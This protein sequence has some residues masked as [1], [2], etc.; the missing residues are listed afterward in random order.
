MPSRSIRWPPVSLTIGTSHF[1]ATSAILRSCAGVVTPP[2]ICGTTEKVPS[3]W[4][5]ACT[6]SLMNLA[7]FSSMYSSAHIILS[8]EASP[9]LDFASSAP[10]G[11]SAAKTED[12]DRRPCSMIAAI[13]S[14]LSIGI[15]GTYQ[16]ADG[17]STTA[18][19]AAHS[20]IW[21]T[22]VL[23]EPQPLPALVLSIT[24]ATDL[25]AALHAGDQGALG[26]AV[27]VADLGV[28]GEF[29][30]ADLGRRGAEVEQHLQPFLGQRQPAVERLHQEGDLGAVAE[31]RCADELLVPDDQRLVDAAA[32]LGEHDVLVGVPLRALHAHRGD[33]DAGHLELGRGPRAVV[34]GVRVGAGDLVGQ[35]DGLLPERRDQAVDLAAVLHAFADREDVGVVHRPHLVV[36]DDRPLDGEAAGHGQVDVRPDA[37][38]DDHHVALEQRVVE[39]PDPA[40]LV[41]AHDRGGAGLGVHLDAERSRHSC[42]GC[43]RRPG[44][45][46]RSSDAVRRAPRRPAGR[47]PAVRGRP[48]ARAGRRR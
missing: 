43:R 48:P 47:R 25:H 3:F 28:V 7:S 40:D 19:P 29:G 39:Q 24:P 8:S 27:A 26:D 12:T 2:F 11:A 14:G 5:L 13:S 9:I 1:S 18:P 38:R 31:H 16:F 10:S 30:D 6:R 45:S 34:G 20:T 42:A 33:I 17:S 44:R 15:P 37:G 46:G 21:Q 22:M 41:L 32:R 23:Q 36:D 35:H 4:M